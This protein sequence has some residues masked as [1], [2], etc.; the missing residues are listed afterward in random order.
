MIILTKLLIIIFILFDPSKIKNFNLDTRPLGI[1]V[2][3]LDDC[4]KVIDLVYD[5]RVSF[6]LNKMIFACMYFNALVRSNELVEK[7][8]EYKYFRTG[9]FK[10]YDPVNQETVTMNG[11]PLSNGFSNLI[12][13]IEN[14]IMIYQKEE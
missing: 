3:G 12:Y 4:F 8:G 9:S 1:G 5:S 14:N 6:I 7:Y 10:I 13:G 2:S 11:S